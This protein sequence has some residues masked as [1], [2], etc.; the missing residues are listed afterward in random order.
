VKSQADTS[1]QIY[2]LAGQ[3]ISSSAK[4]ILIKDG[5]KFIK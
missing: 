4:G 5:K 2:N 3:R 1:A